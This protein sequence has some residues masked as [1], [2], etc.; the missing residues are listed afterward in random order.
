MSIE[1]ARTTKAT[2]ASTTSTTN[3]QPIPREL[4]NKM[5]VTEQSQDVNQANVDKSESKDP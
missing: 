3:I 4:T 1:N 5:Y 2:T